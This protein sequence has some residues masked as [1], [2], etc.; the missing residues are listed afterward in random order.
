MSQ[1]YY[2]DVIKEDEMHG[3]ATAEKPEWEKRPLGRSRNRWNSIT[4]NLGQRV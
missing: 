1:N 4:M 2:S 3:H